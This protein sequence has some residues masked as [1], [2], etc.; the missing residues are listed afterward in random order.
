ML[1]EIL[2]PV[3]KELQLIH[4]LINNQL[5]I[6]AGYLGSFAHLELSPTDRNIRPA[7]VVLSSRIFSYDPK[8]SIV[9]AGIFQFI[10]LAAK[11]QQ[12]VSE[13]D[14]NYVR[15]NTDPKDGSQFP[16]LIGDYIYSKFFF[17]TSNANITDILNTLA[18]IICQIHEGSLL[19]KIKNVN[20][21]PGNI[22][23]ELVK[24]ETASLFAGCCFLTARLSGAPEKE[25]HS[26]MHFGYNLGVAYGMLEQGIGKEFAAPYLEKALSHLAVFPN[27]PEKNILEKLVGFLQQSGH[28]L[29]AQRMVI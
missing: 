18:E 21:S 27:R 3:E 16:V 25:Q 7:L 29:P 12:G 6:K 20:N 9:L 8:K 4:E 26:I 1:S 22:M 23:I 28:C 2:K 15:E 5:T 13:V 11:V 10:Y 14:S 17:F 24:K 19:R